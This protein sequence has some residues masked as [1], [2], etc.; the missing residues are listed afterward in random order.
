MDIDGSHRLSYFY[1][2]IVP[3]GLGSDDEPFSMGDLRTLAYDV[4]LGP[5]PS[6]RLANSSAGW[7]RFGK[8]REA[9]AELEDRPEY[10]LDLSF[11]YSLLSLGYEL[12][13]D[14]E[15]RTGKKINDV[16]LGWYVLSVFDRELPR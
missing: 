2:R 12:G 11:M 4:C 3:L 1:D 7:Q 13:D 14:R 10:C 15:L 8:N 16:E 6:K 9:M 5:T